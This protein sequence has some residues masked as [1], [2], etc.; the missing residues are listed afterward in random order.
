MIKVYLQDMIEVLVD[1]LQVDM[2]Q[3]WVQSK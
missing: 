1:R 2:M 3:N